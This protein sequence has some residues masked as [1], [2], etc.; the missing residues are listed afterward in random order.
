VD[1][2]E[3]AHSFPFFGIP[4]LFKREGDNMTKIASSLSIPQKICDHNY[5]IS[6]TVNGKPQ[7]VAYAQDDSTIQGFSSVC[8]VNATFGG[9]IY[10]TASQLMVK[11]SR[12]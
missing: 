7:V 12:S 1:I 5:G 11:L 2:P 10:S 9:T 6:E 3:Y 4:Q 8:N